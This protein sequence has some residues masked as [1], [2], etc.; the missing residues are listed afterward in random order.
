MTQATGSG[1]EIANVGT[2][3]AYFLHNGKPLLSFGG[4]ADVTFYLNEDAY[5]YRRWAT[6]LADHGMNHIRAVK[7]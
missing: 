3:R 7:S 6:W 5:N 4:M 2:E 1:L